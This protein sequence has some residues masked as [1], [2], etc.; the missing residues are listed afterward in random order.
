MTE[1]TDD[2]QTA[3]LKATLELI[4]ENG[5]HG[6]PMSLVAQEAGVGVGT[7]YRYFSGKEELIN[8]L[9]L[10]VKTHLTQ[11][12]LAGYDESLPIRTRFNKIWFN[13]AH[14][15][16]DHPKELRFL[17]QYAKSPYI[18]KSTKIEGDQIW[19]PLLAFIRYAQEQQVVKN[20][21]F[22]ILLSMVHGPIVSLVMFHLTE[23]FVLDDATLSM[24]ADA[25]WDAVKR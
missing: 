8:A 9:Y 14:Y 19:Q 10:H 25:A 4:S 7:I 23:D 18:N 21:P 22:E 13:L 20:I 24:A 15:Y 11:A 17:E 1:T 12:L 6:T 3:I 2:K 5:F 16:L